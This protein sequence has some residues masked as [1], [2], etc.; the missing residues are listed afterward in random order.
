MSLAN[1]FGEKD[2]VASILGTHLYKD[3]TVVVTR[4][5]YSPLMKRINDELMKA[6]DNTSNDIE[7]D[8]LEDYVASFYT[9]SI[10]SHKNGSR[11]WI[12]N[13]GPIVETWV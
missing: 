13:K 11:H 2:N 6:K 7:T 9:G 4:G 3:T 10:D 1:P 8:M 12:K 5:D